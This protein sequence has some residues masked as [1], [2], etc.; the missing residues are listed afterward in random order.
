M[1]DHFYHYFLNLPSERSRGRKI[2]GPIQEGATTWGGSG[3]GGE[4]KMKSTGMNEMSDRMKK[5]KEKKD[6][7]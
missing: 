5:D 4:P 1:T 2:E 6:G 7:K 3:G